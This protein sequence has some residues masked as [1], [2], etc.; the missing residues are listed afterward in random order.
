MSTS[1]TEVAYIRLT[2][3]IPKQ[4]S[5]KAVEEAV[6]MA[7][8]AIKVILGRQYKAQIQRRVSVRSRSRQPEPVS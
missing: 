4:L 6:T 7:S 8:S 5:N 1:A 2:L 3:E